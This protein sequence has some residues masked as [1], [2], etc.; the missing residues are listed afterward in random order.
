MSV[1]LIT[2][3]S[4]G[5]GREMA[6]QWCAA[7]ATVYGLARRESLLAELAA[8]FPGRFLAF[9]CDVTDRTA[10]RRVCDALPALPDIVVLN[11]G[12]GDAD[13]KDRFDLAVHE[14]SFAD[15]Y[16]GALYFIDALFERFKARG[17]GKF[18]AVASLAAYRGL[19]L[20]AA[21]CSSKAALS[22]AI[23]SMRVSYRG[24]GI[25]FLTVHP[26]FINTPMNAARA[27]KLPFILAPEDAARR[28]IRGVNAGTSNISFPWPLRLGMGLAAMLPAGLYRW[29]VGR[30]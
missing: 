2:G 8:E 27:D 15:N 1:C 16:F 17:A 21:Y 5:I 26:G 9:P 19:P 10:V 18:V 11:A 6:R 20:S 4:S 23:E 28:I 14:R 25:E 12:I 30:K 29:A 22:I 13:P 7:G 3:A 24:A